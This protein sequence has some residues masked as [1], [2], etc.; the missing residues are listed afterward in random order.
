MEE[1]MRERR[2]KELKCMQAQGRMEDIKSSLKVKQDI[3]GQ[4]KDY[5]QSLQN[6]L[7]AA[8][9]ETNALTMQNRTLKAAASE[10]EDVR[11]RL[12]EAR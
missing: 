7:K 12:L 1:L 2:E 9:N 6:Q 10:N 4:S 11:Q 3:F 5:E 8:F